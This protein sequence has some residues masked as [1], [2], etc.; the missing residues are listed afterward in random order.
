MPFVVMGGTYTV[1]VLLE[2]IIPRLIALQWILI[3]LFCITGVSFCIKNMSLSPDTCDMSY[4]LVVNVCK[5]SI[6]YAEQNWANDTIE[7]NFPV[8][9]GLQDPRNGYLT[10]KPIPYSANFVKPTKF[11]LLFYLW[12]EG[13]IPIG[14][15]IK[16]HVVK[17]FDDGYAHVAAVEFER[18][19]LQ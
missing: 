3:T 13:N 11:G 12:G 16:Y 14:N 8:Y 19:D 5:E 17:T 9:Q 10:G 1:L 15:K 4:K 7:A 2:K 18:G 6:H